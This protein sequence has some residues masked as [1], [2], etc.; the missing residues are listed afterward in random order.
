MKADGSPETALIKIK[1]SQKHSV[2]C[3]SQ[4]EVD[5]LGQRSEALVTTRTINVV[6]RLCSVALSSPGG[7]DG[8]LGLATS[9][10]GQQEVA[11]NTRLAGGYLPLAGAHSLDVREDGVHGLALGALHIHEEGVRALYQSLQLVDVLFLRGVNV[12]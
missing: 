5:S 9:G 1:R 3:R 12:Q 11:S 4:S 7:A 6:S 10:D 2:S 8:E